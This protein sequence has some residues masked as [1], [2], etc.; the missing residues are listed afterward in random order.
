MVPHPFSTKVEGY[1][2]NVSFATRFSMSSES[3]D[4]SGKYLI[5]K[6]FLPWE[7]SV[8]IRGYVWK[9][10]TWARIFVWTPSSIGHRLCGL[11]KV[12]PSLQPPLICDDMMTFSRVKRNVLTQFG[13]PRDIR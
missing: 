1:H 7:L 2:V 12:S 8:G 9:N 10:V 4:T 6:A 5:L 11:C 13:R 3:M